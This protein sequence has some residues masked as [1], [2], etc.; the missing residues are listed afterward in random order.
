MKKLSI[1]T[2]L[3]ISLTFI[4]G[5]T[6]KS[7]QEICLEQVSKER[8]YCLAQT[9]RESE[10]NSTLTNLSIKGAKASCVN[11]ALEDTFKC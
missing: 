3:L 1:L 8:D 7:P 5:C 10:D 9:G 2:I 6:E 4:I 11:K